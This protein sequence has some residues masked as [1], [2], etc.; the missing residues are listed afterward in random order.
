MR[1][2]EQMTDL[3]PLFSSFW[4]NETSTDMSFMFLLSVL[5]LQLCR[6]HI[7]EQI[8]QKTTTRSCGF[9]RCM[10]HWYFLTFQVDIWGREGVSVGRLHAVKA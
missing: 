1:K 4:N 10:S 6:N 3:T 7:N 8:I 9:L 5:Y 2:T